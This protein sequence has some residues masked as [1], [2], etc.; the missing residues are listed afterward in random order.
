[1]IDER[2]SYLAEK[3]R[4]APGSTL[5]AVVGAGHIAGM[6]EALRNAQAVDLEELERIPPPSRLFTAIAWGFA[7]VMVASI[8]YVG[9][10]QGA[11]AA[12]DNVLFWCLATGVPS[13]IGS[14]LAF[15]HPL[16]ILAALF[17][18]PIT[19]LTPVLGVGYVA[20]FVQCYVVPP[21][22]FEF[23]TVSEQLSN[24]TAWWRSRLLRVFLVFIFSSLGGTAG[25]LVG[26][27]R[28]LSNL[29]S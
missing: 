17:S 2:D 4:R 15:A 21:R 13:A 3:I 9:S 11:A 6:S 22:V 28:L 27:T 26:G 12:R 24:V 1:M 14:A 8:A 18:A 29:F 5:V 23:Q 25:T 19:A 20:A 10:T 7:A 16:T